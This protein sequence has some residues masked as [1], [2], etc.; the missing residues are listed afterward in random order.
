MSTR[1]NAKKENQRLR[2]IT[3]N[4]DKLYEELNPQDLD[5]NKLK[6]SDLVAR[7]IELSSKKIVNTNVEEDEVEDEK[8]KKRQNQ[9]KR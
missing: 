2:V 1:S 9:L 7:L 5:F 8:E 4:A 6:K 3:D